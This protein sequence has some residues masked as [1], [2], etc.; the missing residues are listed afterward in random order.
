MTRVDLIHPPTPAPVTPASSPMPHEPSIAHRLLRWFLRRLIGLVILLVILAA[1]F[2]YLAARSGLVDIPIF[3]AL[4]FK[5]VVPDH[6][7]APSLGIQDAFQQQLQAQHLDPT[8]KSQ[9]LTLVFSESVLTKTLRDYLTAN[10]ADT[11][12]ADKSQVAIT[13]GGLEIFLALKTNQEKT[14]IIAHLAVGAKDGVFTTMLDSAAVGDLVLPHVLANLIIQPS[15]DAAL[16]LLND[17]LIKS[18]RIDSVGFVDNTMTV[19][20]ELTSDLKTITQ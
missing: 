6:V 10:A 2:V 13:N 1:P 3:S 4:L 19:T 12:N 15:L 9:T 5:S 14:A 16:K 7:V 18:T 20:G 8:S 17:Q 11:F